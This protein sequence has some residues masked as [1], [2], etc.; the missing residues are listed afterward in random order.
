MDWIE[1]KLKRPKE[2]GTYK[3]VD[4]FG[5]EYKAKYNDNWDNWNYF[6]VVKWRI[7]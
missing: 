5:N 7:I 2:S 4:A 6:S 1:N 3:V